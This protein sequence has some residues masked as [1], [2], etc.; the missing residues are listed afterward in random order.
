MLVTPLRLFSVKNTFPLAKVVWNKQM[1]MF[2]LP[3]LTPFNKRFALSAGPRC[4]NSGLSQ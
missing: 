4:L 1:E 3:F 2:F